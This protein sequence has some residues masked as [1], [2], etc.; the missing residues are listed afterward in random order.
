MQR[1]TTN[2]APRTPPENRENHGHYFTPARAKVRGAVEFCERMGIPYVKADVFRTFKVS[3]SQ[4]YEFLHEESSSRRLHNDPNREETCGRPRIISAEK[5]R[6]MERILQEKGIGARALTCEQ[7]G[8]EVGLECTGKTVK[9]AMG[10]M[11][12][13]KYLACKKGWVNE[14]TAHNRKQW[15]EVKKERYPEPKNCYRV[16]FSDEV[17]FGYSP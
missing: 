3:H 5:I 2:H 1:N 17:Y 6:E 16:H 13:R 9:K 7:L 8:Y 15:V 4:G 11:N 12:Y 14:K 10:S